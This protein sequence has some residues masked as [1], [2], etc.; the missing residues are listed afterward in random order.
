MIYGQN[1]AM[2]SHSGLGQQQRDRF[3]A[4]GPHLRQDLEHY[5]DRGTLRLI[6]PLCPLKYASY[7]Y[8]HGDSLI[9]LT[10][11]ATRR[12]LESRGFECKDFP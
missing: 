12:W 4:I 9:C 6:L 1:R 7:N 5:V 11:K 8:S 3:D 2:H 10:R